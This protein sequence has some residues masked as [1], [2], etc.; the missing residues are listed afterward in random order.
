MKKKIEFK[1]PGY[2]S[3]N[4]RSIDANHPDYIYAFDGDNILVLK[5]EK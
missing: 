4:I 3:C 2:D 1:L 5:Y